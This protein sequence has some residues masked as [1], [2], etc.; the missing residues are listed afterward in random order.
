MVTTL[1]VLAALRPIERLIFPAH[2]PHKVLVRLN[3]VAEAG[4]AIPRVRSICTAASI[5]IESLSLR[6]ARHHGELIAI[7]CR[8]TDVGAVAPA[9]QQLRELPGVNAV[10]ADMREPRRAVGAGLEEQA[11]G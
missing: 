8:I 7:D 11:R 5:Q 4:A 2:G 1:L 9:L 10:H 3:S 6:M